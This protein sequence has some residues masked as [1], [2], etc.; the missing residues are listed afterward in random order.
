VRCDTGRPY[1]TVNQAI[2]DYCWI[3]DTT[4][5]TDDE[6][7]EEGQSEKAKKKKQLV[8]LS[9]ARMLE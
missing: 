5:T 3:L 9:S 6:E 8:V 4:N 2:I 7:A 1:S